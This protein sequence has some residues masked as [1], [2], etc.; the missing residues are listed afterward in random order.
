[1]FAGEKQEQQLS[2]ESE[3]IQH[4]LIHSTPTVLL[5]VLVCVCLEGQSCACVAGSVSLIVIIV[6]FF[7]ASREFPDH[8]ELL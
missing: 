1:M 7:L 4:H 8:W 2:S 3:S 5:C 6:I